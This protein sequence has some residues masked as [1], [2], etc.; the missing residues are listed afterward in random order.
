[1]KLIEELARRPKRIP[2]AVAESELQQG[3]GGTPGMGFTQTSTMPN[4]FGG[5]D[6]YR[7]GTLI[8]SSS[9]N[10]F[11]GFDKTVFSLHGGDGPT[12]EHVES[13]LADI[14]GHHG[15]SDDDR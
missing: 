10:I 9:P 13:A 3:A 15:S 7:N 14:L 1:M 2:A 6:E 5:R 11:G 4:I 12:L 8:S